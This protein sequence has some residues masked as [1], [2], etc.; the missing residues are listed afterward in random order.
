M[1][2]KVVNHWNTHLKIEDLDLA[3]AEHWEKMLGKKLILKFGDILIF[4]WL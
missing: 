1:I 2:A 3:I 4:T